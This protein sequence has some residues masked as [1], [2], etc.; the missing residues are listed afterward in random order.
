[1]ERA[2]NVNAADLAAADYELCCPLIN[3]G[4]ILLTECSSAI[5]LNTSI[6]SPQMTLQ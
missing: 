6:E 4:A 5:V 2:Q 1:M 3:M